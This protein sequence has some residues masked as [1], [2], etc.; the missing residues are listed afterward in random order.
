MWSHGQLLIFAMYA[1]ISLFLLA[2]Y[3]AKKLY[4]LQVVKSF[5]R[6]LVARIL[7]NFKKIHQNYIY[8]VQVST[9]KYW[10]IF[11]KNR[12]SYVAYG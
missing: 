2:I 6:F 4:D 3:V 11:L 1:C 10:R 7:P 8:M 5:L 9:L 12:L